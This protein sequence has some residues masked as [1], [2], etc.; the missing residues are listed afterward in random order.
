MRHMGRDVDRREE[1]GVGCDMIPNQYGR[2]IPSSE[3]R[4]ARAHRVCSTGGLLLTPNV[5]SS[6]SSTSSSTSSTSLACGSVAL[7]MVVHLS[8]LLVR[9]TLAAFAAFAALDLLKF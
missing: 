6:T 5:A 1:D 4:L 9:S 8:V 7:S 3:A 2:I